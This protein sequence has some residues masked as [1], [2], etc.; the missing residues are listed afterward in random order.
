MKLSIKES[1]NL[2]RTEMEDIL[3][4]FYMSP[5]KNNPDL[6]QKWSCSEN[7]YCWDFE[8]MTGCIYKES[9]SYKDLDWETFCKKTKY[10]S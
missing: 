6:W 3:Q 1:V 8:T 9:G 4:G 7:L 5:S 2:S 10:T